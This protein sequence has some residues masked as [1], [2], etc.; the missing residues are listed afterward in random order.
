MGYDHSANSHIPE[1]HFPSFILL[2]PTA[3]AITSLESSTAT[4]AIE[5]FDFDNFSGWPGAV[6]PQ[7]AAVFGLPSLNPR[8]LR[9]PVPLIFE[10][11]PDPPS[12]ASDTLWGFQGKPSSRPFATDPSRGLV[13]LDVSIGDFSFSFHLLKELLMDR[14]KEFREKEEY[15]PVRWEQWW[16]DCWVMDGAGERRQWVTHIHGYVAF[17]PLSSPRLMP[18]LHLH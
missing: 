1:F 16:G 3:F 13:N 14:L 2:S 10:F 18:L 4:P 12:S 17:F 15:V 5:V 8:L 7:R 11:R 6:T 9:L